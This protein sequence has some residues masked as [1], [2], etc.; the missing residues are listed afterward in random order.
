LDAD[1][2]LRNAVT[3]G[4]QAIESGGRHPAAVA[5]RGHPGVEESA[6]E[7]ISLRLFLL[8]WLLLSSAA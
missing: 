7:F 6:F 2:G 8:C 4:E 5:L 3:A 1:C